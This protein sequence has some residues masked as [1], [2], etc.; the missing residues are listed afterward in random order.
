[1]APDPRRILHAM[2][3]APAARDREPMP[4]DS[5]AAGLAWSRWGEAA[6]LIVRGATVHPAGRVA[7][8]VGTLL[9]LVNQGSVLAAGGHTAAT[10]LRVVTNY[11]VPYLV[12]S[13]GYLVSFRRR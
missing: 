6:A 10:L 12:S 8:V 11:V 4:A 5:R 2:T 9:T 7:L 1:M 3:T 13:V